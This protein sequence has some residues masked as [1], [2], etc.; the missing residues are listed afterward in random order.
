VGEGV[1]GESEYLEVGFCEEE[2]K[3]FNDGA[4]DTEDGGVGDIDSEKSI[5]LC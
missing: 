5:D 1:E 4:A 2:G 3:L